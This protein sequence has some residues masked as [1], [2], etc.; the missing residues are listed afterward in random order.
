MEEV[1]KKKLKR[2]KTFIESIAYVFLVPKKYLP[3][4]IKHYRLVKSM[5][6][7]TIV[8]GM[9]M[10]LI[11]VWLILWSPTLDALYYPYWSAVPVSIISA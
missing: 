3:F 5:K 9:L 4:V 11:S 7:I 6:I 8:L 10:C 2:N 1:S